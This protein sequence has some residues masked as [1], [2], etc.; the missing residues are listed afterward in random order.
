MVSATRHRRV[1]RKVRRTRTKK[2]S[3]KKHNT[4]RALKHKRRQA[5]RRTKHNRRRKR[6]LK[7]GNIIKQMS[8]FVGKGIPA[9]KGSLPIA[10]RNHYIQ[11]PDFHAPNGNIVNTSLLQ[12]G[13]GIIPR[14]LVDL[15]RSIVGGVKGSYDTWV[16]QPQNI[17][18]DPNVMDQNLK[19]GQPDASVIDLTA[20]QKRADKLAASV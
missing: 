6:N 10:G 9:G 15:G 18:D 3:T 1:K 16:G 20:I 4:R 17:S 5:R 2:H 11:C 14:D 7:G 13:G 8:P 19:Y 12:N